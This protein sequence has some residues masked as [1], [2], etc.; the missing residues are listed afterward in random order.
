MKTA[1]DYGVNFFD[2]ADIY[3][4]GNGEI[5]MGNII[6]KLGLNRKDLVISSKVFWPTGDGPNDRGLSR[7]HIMESVHASLQRLNTDYLDFYFCHRYD[8]EVQLEEVVRAMD[9]LVHQGKVLYWGTSEWRAGQIASAVAVAR[10]WGLYT[11][12]VEQP[13]Y[14]M[15]HRQIVE[16]ELVDAAHEH[17]VGLVVWSPLASGILT[18]KYNEGFPAGSRMADPNY[19]WLRQYVT[20]DKIEKVRQLTALSTE[21]GMTVAQLAL[22]WLLRL[23]EISSVITGASRPEQVHEN[24]KALTFKDKLTPDVLARIESILQANAPAEE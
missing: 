7:K 14:H 16:T 8:P 20:A 6:R 13:Q 3:S 10:Q 23:P 18:G 17:G 22:V 4:M 21:L 5:V 11:P 12:A 1:W 15:L 2:N 9:D 24:M 19:E